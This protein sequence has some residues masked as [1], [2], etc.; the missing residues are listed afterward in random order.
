MQPICPASDARHQ[1]SGDGNHDPRVMRY[2]VGTGASYEIDTDEDTYHDERSGV[3]HLVSGWIQQAQ[4]E[5][6]S[7]IHHAAYI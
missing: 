4:A 1:Y 5:K 7:F 2:E 6:V 3:H